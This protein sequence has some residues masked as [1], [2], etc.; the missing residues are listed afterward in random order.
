MHI[1]RHAFK[2]LSF[3]GGYGGKA[4]AGIAAGWISLYESQGDRGKNIAS[5]DHVFDLQHNTGSVF[6]KLKSYYKDKTR[7]KWLEYAL[8]KKRDAVSLYE[9]LPYVSPNLKNFI[10]IETRRLGQPAF[11]D[12]AKEHRFFFSDDPEYYGISDLGH[13]VD[14]DSIKKYYPW[15]LKADMTGASI[16]LTEEYIKGQRGKGHKAKSKLVPMI[17]GATWNGGDFKEGVFTGGTFNGGRFLYGK[18]NESEFNGGEFMDGKFQYSKFNGGDF[19]GGSMSASKF[20]AGDW[21]GGNFIGNE[22][23]SKTQGNP[24]SKDFEPPVTEDPEI[25][26]KRIETMERALES[27]RNGK[28]PDNKDLDFLIANP[29]TGSLKELVYA[30]IDTGK[31][32]PDVLIDAVTIST[33]LGADAQ[34]RILL[35]ELYGAVKLPD[36]LEEFIFNDDNLDVGLHHIDM[37]VNAGKE[38]YENIFR[39]VWDKLPHRDRKAIVKKF[40]NSGKFPSYWGDMGGGDIDNKAL[41]VLAKLELGMKISDDDL[42]GIKDMEGL[43]DV[44][45]DIVLQGITIS[46]TVLKKLFDDKSNA[47]FAEFIKQ[48]A[49]R[50]LSKVSKYMISAMSQSDHTTM[51]SAK[52]EYVKQMALAGK[53]PIPMSV[54]KALNI[55]SRL[56]LLNVL[57]NST[58]PEEFYQPEFYERLNSS[59]SVGRLLVAKHLRGQLAPEGI[60]NYMKD[61]PDFFAEHVFA[62]MLDHNLEIPKFLYNIMAFTPYASYVA[63]KYMVNKGKEVPAVI[64]NSVSKHSG[65]SYE[66]AKNMLSRKRPVYPEILRALAKDPKYGSKLFAYYQKHKMKIPEELS[67]FVYDSSNIKDTI[68]N[69]LGDGGQVTPE[70]I[71]AFKDHENKANLIVDLYN[72]KHDVPVEMLDVID[73]PQEAGVVVVYLIQKKKVVPKKLLYTATSDPQLK[74]LIVNML[75]KDSRPMDGSV[76]GIQKPFFKSPP[77]MSAYTYLDRG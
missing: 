2:D 21:Y 67:A 64:L 14:L 16:S 4:W 23:N 55:S 61:H 36:A 1:A 3:N 24:N 47:V 15:I 68:T 66:I 6:N 29:N 8:D 26:Q 44:L 77:G 34:L 56:D 72:A 17:T 52:F 57:P 75:R 62:G 30:Y 37:Y 53:S 35:M 20:N 65:Y 32:L 13:N 43:G 28:D 50:D 10:M 12:W 31:E 45:L 54:I 69:S 70:I 27:I 25:T 60:Y 63:T 22:W 48:I 41:I 40:L 33:I 51:M 38:P 5:I 11:G 46:D 19:Y 58:Y 42:L 73:D 18:F 9:L 74:N 76:I 49:A 71:S 59:S 39:K 7:Y